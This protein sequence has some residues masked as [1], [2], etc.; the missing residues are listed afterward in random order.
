MRWWLRPT[1]SRPSLFSCS[2]FLCCSS[3]RLLGVCSRFRAGSYVFCLFRCDPKLVG[4]APVSERPLW[5]FCNLSLVLADAGSALGSSPLSGC[6]SR[7]V[8]YRLFQA[9]LAPV[10]LFGHVCLEPFSVQLLRFCSHVWLLRALCR[11]CIAVCAIVTAAA[12][13]TH[14][15]SSVWLRGLR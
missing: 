3:L 15:C 14:P 7:L 9:F 1:T 8:L 6:M 10:S 11:I 2:S 13:A 5:Q 4:V 12:V